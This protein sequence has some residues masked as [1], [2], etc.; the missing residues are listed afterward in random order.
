MLCFVHGATARATCILSFLK[1]QRLI[2]LVTRWST[3]LIMDISWHGS[4]WWTNVLWL[5]PHFS[6]AKRAE[7]CW[8]HPLVHSGRINFRV[9]T[10]SEERSREHTQLLEKG[11]HGVTTH[12]PRARSSSSTRAQ[13]RPSAAGQTPV[14]ESHLPSP[15]PAIRKR[16]FHRTS[17]AGRFL[18]E[19][20]RACKSLTTNRLEKRELGLSNIEL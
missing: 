8:V 15:R 5:T 9:L 19:I 10:A 3:S 20:R 1:K 14:S 4:C 17:K 6:K 13:S 18:C 11:M 12:A 2:P 7:S 16:R